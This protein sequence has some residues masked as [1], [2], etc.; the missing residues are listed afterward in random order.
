MKKCQV[1]FSSLNCDDYSIF[2]A[3]VER[4]AAPAHAWAEPRTLP[5]RCTTRAKPSLRSFNLE[6]GDLETQDAQGWSR[7]HPARPHANGFFIVA[8][9][10]L[11]PLL[12]RQAQGRFSRH[13]PRAL[14][15]ALGRH[16]K[17]EHVKDV[18]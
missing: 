8:Q 6:V 5:E 12:M 16:V 14:A 18:A 2:A 15:T 3:W 17:D 1:K 11:N 7:A 13:L 4:S 9:C 10:S